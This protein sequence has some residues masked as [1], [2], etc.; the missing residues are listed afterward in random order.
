[1][2]LPAQCDEAGA[3]ARVLAVLCE[4]ETDS[5]TL[6]EFYRN[7]SSFATNEPNFLRFRVV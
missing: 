7:I 1:M 2:R 6:P 5:L 4:A 3:V